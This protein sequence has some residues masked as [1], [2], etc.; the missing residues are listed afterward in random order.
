MANDSS[1]DLVRLGEYT[2]FNAAMV[3]DILATNGIEAQVM[4]SGSGQTPPLTTLPVVVGPPHLLATVQVVVRHADMQ[5]AA[6]GIKEY[7]IG[8]EVDKGEIDAA[9]ATG[10]LWIT[11]AVV[12]LVALAAC[13]LTLKNTGAI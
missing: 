11:V 5:K 4:G 3:R 7:E 2:E 13:F 1:N 12:I 6:A 9:T 10:K 8:K